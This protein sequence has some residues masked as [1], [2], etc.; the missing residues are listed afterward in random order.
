[1]K[2]MTVGEMAVQERAAISVFKE[3]GI[4]FCCNGSK[5]IEEALREKN[6]SLETFAAKL[7]AA[8]K[9][10]TSGATGGAAGKVDFLAM[11]PA[12]LAEYIFDIH[13]A[14]LWKKLPETDAL[15]AKVLRVHGANHPELFK[16]YK[17]FG[18]LKT[19]LEQH[20]IKEETMLFPRIAQ[21]DS[22]EVEELTAGIR[23]EHEQ[24][25]KLL[26]QLRTVTHDYTLPA[27][28]CMSFRNLYISLQ[29][30]EDD[31]HEHIH[32]ENNILLKP[33]ACVR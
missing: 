17:L 20:L 4:D 7:E 29:E 10:M 32:L 33:I 19:D 30:M 8:K 13:H 24:A 27:D 16:A 2:N 31:L 26:E 14:Y 5:T 21:V 6:I 23:D 11:R 3:L 28:A 25:G 18:T 1:M 15:F 9:E 12:D 22:A